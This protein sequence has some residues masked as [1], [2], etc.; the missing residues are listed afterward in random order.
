MIKTINKAIIIQEEKQ[1]DLTGELIINRKN[2]V[3]ARIVIDNDVIL[4]ARNVL[5]FPVDLDE[6]QILLDN[7]VSFH[8]MN[9]G[10]WVWVQH[11]PDPEDGS[12]MNGWQR[13]TGFWDQE[14]IK[15]GEK[16]FH[17]WI[18]GPRKRHGGW[19]YH[20]PPYL[21]YLEPEL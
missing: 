4:V 6:W 7:T 19:L 16:K 15:V 20:Y 1:I 12:V 8:P 21:P 17:F 5:Y 14:T 13:V 10:D 9:D 3:L 18:W 2:P 11:A